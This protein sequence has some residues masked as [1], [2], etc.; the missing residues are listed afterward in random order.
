MGTPQLNISSS[1][2]TL[3]LQSHPYLLSHSASCGAFYLPGIRFTSRRRVTTARAAHAKPMFLA[4]ATVSSK[5][6][7][8]ASEECVRRNE[9][10]QTREHRLR[11]VKLEI[12]S[13]YRR[14]CAECRPCTVQYTN[15]YTDMYTDPET[16]ADKHTHAHACKVI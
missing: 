10:V 14:R 5:A 13:T 7:G 6:P 12:T 11:Q 1:A 16:L 15:M 8:A 4:A 2:A 9:K 3:T